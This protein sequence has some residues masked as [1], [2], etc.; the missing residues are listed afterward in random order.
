M[1]GYHSKVLQNRIRSLHI[2]VALSRFWRKIG[3]FGVGYLEKMGAR[4][5]DGYHERIRR[6]LENAKT[7]T[8]VSNRLFVESQPQKECKILYSVPYNPILI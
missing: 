4:T 1:F 8:R 5:L 3:T 6:C 2:G 7:I